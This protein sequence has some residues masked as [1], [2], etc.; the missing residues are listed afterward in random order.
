[1]ETVQG[2]IQALREPNFFKLKL[3]GNL[4]LKYPLPKTLELCE[5]ILEKCEVFGALL[6]EDALECLEVTLLVLRAFPI[7]MSKVAPLLVQWSNKYNGNSA[8]TS[9]T[10]MAAGLIGEINSAVRAPIYRK[11][12]QLILD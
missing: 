3:G 11:R 1:M 2:D 8:F 6:V 12:H 7:L 10:V 4:A 5:V 9:A